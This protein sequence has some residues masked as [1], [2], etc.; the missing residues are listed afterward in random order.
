MLGHNH[1]YLP[2]LTNSCTPYDSV[3][4]DAEAPS[5]CRYLDAQDQDWAGLDRK[6]IEGQDDEQLTINTERM[7]TSK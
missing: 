4:D 6:E 5:P 1:L 7:S 3:L 2:E